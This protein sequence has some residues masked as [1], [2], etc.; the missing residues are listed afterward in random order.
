MANRFH[1]LKNNGSDFP[2][3]SNIDVYKFDNDLDYARYDHT[4][5]SLQICTVPWDVGE[6]HV[7]QRTI[8]GIGNVVYFGDKAKRDSWFD[9]IPDN[10]CYRFD[11][12]FKELHREQ[13]IDVP[14]P[15]DMC[16]KHNY[17]VVR[18]NLLANDDSPLQYENED[19]KRDWFWFIREVEF[20]APNTTRLHLL[21]DAFQTWIYDV[22]ITNM[23]LERGHAPMF[24]MR[25]D[26]Y[27]RNPI[28]NNEYLLT[29]DVS[30][31]DADNL[32]HTDVLSLNSDDVWACMATTANPL[33][34]FGT[35]GADTW[36]TP[37]SAHYLSNGVPST[38]VFAIEP[39]ELN[40]FLANVTD[41]IPQFKQTIQGVFFA[42]KALVR[43]TGAFIFANVNCNTVESSQVQMEL[44]DLEK[45]QF[46]YPAR[47]EDMAK[48]YTFPYAH[49]EV[50]DESGKV[51]EVRIETTD[52]TLDVGV[53]LS[54]AFPF[55]NIEAHILGKGGGERQS[56][57]F[58]NVTSRSFAFQGLWY[59]TL[60]EW[61]VPTFAVVLDASREYDYSTHFD[62]KQAKVAYENAYDS[63][64]AS[65]DTAF[66]NAIDNA[67]TT[68]TNS[69][70]TS[71]V[72]RD[73]A[74]RTADTAKANAD[75]AAQTAKT[76]ADAVADTA[77]SNDD[78]NADT[79]IDNTAIQ[80]AAN[81][82]IATRSN[83]ASMDD[84][85]LSNDL[86][87]SLQAWESGYSRDN[88]NY[89]QDAAYAT[90]AIGAAGGIAN[91]AISGAMSGAS[92]GPA[93]AA[94]GAIGGLVSGAISGACSIAQTAVAA[95]LTYQQSEASIRLSQQKVTETS[96]NNID[97]TDTQ[98]DANMDNIG[99][100]NTASSGASANSAACT[101]EN[102]TRVR[103]TTKA[104]ATRD[105][106]TANANALASRTTAVTNATNQYSTE[107][108]NT[109]RTYD[110]TIQNADRV[111]DTAY[112]NADRAKDTA[113]NAIENS[114]KQAALRSPFLYGN[115]ADGDT[116]TTKPIALFANI[117]TQGKAA[118]AAAGDEFARYGYALDMQWEF[119]G[120]WN[121]GKYFTYWK[122]RDFWVS[123]LN[124]PDLY[125][126]KLR[127]FLFGGV[128]VWSAPEHIGNVDIYDNF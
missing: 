123:G 55:V 54:L 77:K 94:V 109:T 34:D 128:T 37:A 106:D 73:N 116:A 79:L 75:R 51:D 122:L 67:Y 61:K 42:S 22:N 11:T 120:D 41:L 18:Y 8:S 119:D 102:A 92:A 89:Q 20:L 86:S 59:D 117:V 68:R 47:Y 90:A 48:L 101:K 83:T 5:M 45:S 105:K 111:K 113:Q 28:E 93:G 43:T 52:G 81:S 17:L 65:A 15:Y 3:V 100:S 82:S 103:D 44:C 56:V 7:G 63:A 31:G 74:T 40:T 69:N 126:D 16:A 30:F 1:K 110:R 36:H 98:N 19:G 78:N 87:Q 118:I 14:I 125:M 114:I 66:Q 99:Y 32:K 33:S 80:V 12:K 70:A 4:Q 127:F 53:A 84:A 26:D 85:N 57:T 88:V 13:V 10:E 112:D 50:T 107:V 95:N 124:V 64:I 60:H 58:R 24:H 21:D 76:N 2:H 25:A 9:A 104:N 71:T 39:S 121:V 91:G 108:D 72:T 23:I 115:F 97:R 49:I 27:L 96:T 35:K 38:Y 62:R 6:A 29:E 46:G